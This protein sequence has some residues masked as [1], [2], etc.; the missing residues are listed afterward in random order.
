MS[1]AAWEDLK[2]EICTALLLGKENG[3]AELETMARIVWVERQKYLT[4]PISER[5]QQFF[6]AALEAVDKP[7]T[8]PADRERVADPG[9]GK[10]L[11]WKTRSR[12]IGASISPYP[13]DP[14]ARPTTAPPAVMRHIVPWTS[15]SRITKA[16]SLPGGADCTVL[17][18]I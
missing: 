14:S 8:S 6:E 1:A 2:E 17:S 4:V 9:K 10:L 11:K 13:Q 16:R 5:L 18:I 3:E 12:S 7:V 15:I